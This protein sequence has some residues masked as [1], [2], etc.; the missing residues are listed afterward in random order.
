MS[1][2]S[3]SVFLFRGHFQDGREREC[4]TRKKKKNKQNWVRGYRQF[5][6]IDQSSE[7]IKMKGCRPRAIMGLPLAL[8]SFLVCVIFGLI[9]TL[10]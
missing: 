3:A 9:E 7:F 5:R 2:F 10:Y 4:V 8:M 1:F 6:R